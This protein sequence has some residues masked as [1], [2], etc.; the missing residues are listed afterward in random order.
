MRTLLYYVQG[1]GIV[2]GLIDLWQAKRYNL[3]WNISDFRLLCF[4]TV[5]FSPINF[6]MVQIPAIVTC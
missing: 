2:M 5:L 6:A 3:D 1:L 4:G